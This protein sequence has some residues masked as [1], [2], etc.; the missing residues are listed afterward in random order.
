MQQARFNILEEKNILN[1]IMGK[2]VQD[3]DWYMLW[4]LSCI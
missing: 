3:T 4:I 1:N 2:T